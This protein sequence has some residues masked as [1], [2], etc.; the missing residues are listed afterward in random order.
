MLHKDKYS[1]EERYKIAQRM[2]EIVKNNGRIHTRVYGLDNLPKE[3]GYVMYPNHQGKYDALGIIWAHKQPCSFL[4]DDKKSHSL[5]VNEIV[6]LCEAGRLNKEDPKAQVKMFSDVTKRV[7]AGR[8]YIIFP[9]GGYTDNGN[10]VQE[11]MP[12][13]FKCSVRAKTPIVPVL[14]VDSYKVFGV[15]SLKPVTTQ[16]HF[17]PSIPYEEYSE[18][19]TSEIAEMV[20]GR[21]VTA[22]KKYEFMET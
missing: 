20:R 6:Q 21:I 11:F 17:L 2:I 22:M 12:G 9:E 10:R 3:G 1:L 8:K 5:F 14:L 19:S 13:S 4:M 7:K 16:V 18:L 15:N